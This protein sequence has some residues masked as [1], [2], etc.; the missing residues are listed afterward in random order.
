MSTIDGD[1]PAA[2]MLNES[3]GSARTERVRRTVELVRSRL[4]ADLHVVATRDPVELEAWLRERIGP[5][6]R[7]VIVGGDGTLGVTYNA[8]AGRSD[9]VLGYVPA[10]FGNATAHLLR[11]PREPENLA[12]LVVD[13]EA[14]PV[15]L[16]A[17]DG[18]L[19]LFVGAGWDARVA[20]R[21]A[22]GGARRLVGWGQAVVASV[23]DLWRQMDIEV[24]ADGWRVHRGPAEMLVVS[25][26][27]FYGRGLLVNPGARP[28]AGRLVLRVYAASVPGLAAESA[29]WLFRARPKARPVVARR[30][31]L[32]S[33]D[34]RPIPVQA[35]G[36]VL[37]ERPRW[38][39][40][41]RPA[42]VR[43]IGRWA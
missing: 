35:D 2:I 38:Q 7:L 13:G 5:Y 24:R 10:G 42:A 33:T 25:T 23:P 36:D 18:R 34:E 9:L 29:R 41:V 39:L 32:Q 8:A 17:V 40:E 11:L 14:R 15:D 4:D 37:G 21:Y 26:T 3:A 6:E 30:V 20:R 28:D 27:P 1:A 31:E 22:A 19:S 43:L 12:D 16:V